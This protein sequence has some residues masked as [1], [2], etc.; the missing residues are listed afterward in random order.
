MAFSGDL[1]DF[2]V[3]DLLFYLSSKRQSGWLTLCHDGV[4]LT[5]TLQDGQPVEARSTIADHR[6][7]A[8]LVA[9][10]LLTR[11]QLG[12]ALA[13]QT[14]RE[15]TPSLGALLVKLDILAADAV[16]Q[17]IY[18]QLHALLEQLLLRPTGTF[19][20]TR[21]LPE[22]RGLDLDLNLEREVLAAIGRADEQ[23]AAQLPT[24][25]LSLMH[26]ATP[27]RLVGAVGEDWPLFEAL[28]DGATSVA[29]AVAGSG[30]STAE[31]TAGLAR[32]HAQGVVRVEPPAAPSS[33]DPSTTP[34]RRRAVREAVA[35]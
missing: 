6:L 18:A 22:V 31:V 4:E 28:L 1:I 5:L 25:R 8:R 3:P 20:F 12:R 16:R 34:P 23:F 19:R 17:A 35:S 9:D 24:A 2:P 27:E 7:G 14:L 29:A 13:H 30:W 21:G 15:P 32:L 33:S 26:D 11:A 10:G